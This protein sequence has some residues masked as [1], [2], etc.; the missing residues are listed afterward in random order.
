MGYEE[1]ADVLCTLPLFLLLRWGVGK[2]FIGRK[3]KCLE[4]EPSRPWSICIKRL[5]ILISMCMNVQTSEI[6][7]Q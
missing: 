6:Y 1:I 3:K 4:H 7:A 2:A 5:I